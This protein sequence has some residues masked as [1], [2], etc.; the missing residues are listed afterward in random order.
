MHYLRKSKPS[1]DTPALIPTPSAE[2]VREFT[3][4]KDFKALAATSSAIALSIN[5]AF[6]DTYG[7]SSDDATVQGTDAIRQTTYA[8]VRMA[9]EIAKESS[10]LCLPLKAVVG[11]VF[12]LMKNYD[13]SIAV[14]ELNTF[15]F[16]DCFLLQQTSDNTENAKDMERRVQ[17]LYGV[18]ASPVSEDDFAE[19]A[20]RVELRRFVFVRICISLLIPLS[21]SSTGLS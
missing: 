1:A 4:R 13:V 19:K 7:P 11:A 14:C 8:A 2:V 10:D 9:V 16:F 18:L 20:R 15:S 5:S 12:A 6:S 21:G 3:S 17:S